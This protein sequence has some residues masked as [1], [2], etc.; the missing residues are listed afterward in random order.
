M[1]AECHEFGA[2]MDYR[3]SPLSENTKRRR[4]GRQQISRHGILTGATAVE[5]YVAFH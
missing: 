4:Y 3:M 2:S 1:Q 5:T